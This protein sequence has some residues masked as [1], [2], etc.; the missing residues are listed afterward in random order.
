MEDR[1]KKKAL[2][3]TQKNSL[4]KGKGK[5]LYLQTYSRVGYALSD[6]NKLRGGFS[7]HGRKNEIKQVQGFHN[8]SISERRRSKK[9]E[10]GRL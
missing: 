7:L 5:L 4:L 6:F 1:R 2:R 10:S 8:N 9:G 3:K